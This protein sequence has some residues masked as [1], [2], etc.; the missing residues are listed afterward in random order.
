MF[1]PTANGVG[2]VDVGLSPKG[3]AVAAL[4][5]VVVVIVVA[6]AAAVAVVDVVG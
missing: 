2:V 3:F 5:V 4:F 1:A 6:V